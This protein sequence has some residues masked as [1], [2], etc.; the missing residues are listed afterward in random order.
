MIRAEGAEEAGPGP[1]RRMFKAGRGPGGKRPGTSTSA[2]AE[3]GAGS[4][5]REVRVGLGS[6]EEAADQ[7]FW[8]DSTPSKGL[9]WRTEFERKQGQG[10]R[11]GRRHQ[12]PWIQRGKGVQARSKDSKGTPG[13]PVGAHD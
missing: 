1:K 2:G 13:M 7:E 6:K 5:G 9:M 4:E 3:A 8:R 10:A 11:V 12:L